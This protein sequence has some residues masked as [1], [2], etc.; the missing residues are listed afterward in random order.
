M[1][2][3]IIRQTARQ[4]GAERRGNAGIRGEDLMQGASCQP[5]AGQVIVYCLHTERQDRSVGPGQ[6]AAKSFKLSDLCLQLFQTGRGAGRVTG[7]MP[8]LG[9]D[10][11]IGR[12]PP[13][14]PFLRGKGAV[15]GISGEP[16]HRLFQCCV[17]TNVLV[18]F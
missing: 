3:G 17:R 18:L 6:R 11:K 9:I 16:R 1:V 7:W 5:A 15:P 14:S 13:V 10:R 12:N 8:G 4:Q 2:L